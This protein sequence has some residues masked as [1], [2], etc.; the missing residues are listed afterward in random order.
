[1]NENKYSFSVISLKSTI[2]H[3]VS[4]FVI[5]LLALTFLD[6]SAKFA[7]PIV[8]NVFRQTDHPLVAAGPLFQVLRGFLFGIAFYFLREIIFP[9][10]Y[11]WLT[12]WLVLV[13]VGILSPFG[14]APSSIEGMIFTVL[15]A[16]FHLVGYPEV[17]VQA[18]LL[19]FLTHYWVNHPEKKWLNWVFG[20]IFVLSVLMSSLGILAALGMLPASG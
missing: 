1:M 4:Y 19:A 17:V 15:P 7:D 8:A 10:K 6:Y 5:G 9:R 18:G 13:I 11:G 3:T 12:L 2:V 20:I 16:W 14:A